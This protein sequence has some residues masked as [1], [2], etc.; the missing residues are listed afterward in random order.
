L[1]FNKFSLKKGRLFMKKILLALLVLTA[2]VPAMGAVTITMV[3]GTEP[4]AVIVGYN[5]SGGEEVRAFALN[6]AVS[7][8]AYVVGSA[9]R[10]SNDYYV[11]PTNITFEVVDDN[12]VINQYGS[13]VVAA[14]ANGC[15]IE[16]ASLYAAGDPC[17]HTSA[18]P[19]SGNLVKFFVNCMK[20]GIDQ[21]VDVTIPS[22][23]TQR[24]GVVLTNRNSVTPTLPSVLWLCMT[25]PPACV[26]CP[27]VTYGDATSMTGGRPD[28]KVNAYDLLAF[29]KA[30]GTTSTGNARGTGPNQFNCCCDFTNMPG[31]GPDGK[32]N[33]YDLL[34][35]R[36]YYGQTMGSPCTTGTNCP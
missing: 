33:A 19:S 35:L 12:T 22:V 13:P 8:K 1:D 31:I 7:D 24:G 23:N 27:T 20:R 25:P 26:G 15:I 6:V 29:R 21:K 17:G 18:P 14:D 5:C 10:L 36:R 2:A 4:N 9:T 28:G 3:K 11:T 30:Y 32:V 16:M 34:R